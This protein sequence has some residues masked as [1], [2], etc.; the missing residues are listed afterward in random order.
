[1]VFFQLVSA[2][3]IDNE[4]GNGK[5]SPHKADLNW[6]LPSLGTVVTDTTHKITFYWPPEFGTPGAIIV[7]NKHVREFFLKNVS[8]HFPGH[9]DIN[10]LCNSWIYPTWMGKVCS[11]FTAERVFFANNS[12][13][14][15]ETPVGL[16]SWRRRELVRLKGDGTGKRETWD[17]V[18]DYDVYNDLGDPDNDKN[19]QRTVLGGSQEFPY[20]RRCRTGRQ[21]TKTS[22]AYETRK[23]HCILPESFTPGFYVPPD[24]KFP[25]SSLASFRA[26]FF[27]AFSKKFISD[28]ASNLNVL[29]KHFLNLKEIKNLYSKGLSL[30]IDITANLV[31]D[32][33]PFQMIKGIL[34]TEDQA[35]LK[36]PIP[37]I[38]YHDDVAWMKDEEFARQTLS[39]ANPMV[40]QCLQVWPPSSKLNIQIYGPQESSITDQHLLPYLD[41]ISVDEGIES[42]R[43]FVLDYY[44]AYMPYVKRINELATSK[45]YATRTI[46]FLFS[47]GTLKPIAIELCLPPTSVGLGE[48]RVFTPDSS[49]EDKGWLWQLAKAHVKAN[50]SGYHQIVSHWLRT[51]AVVEPFIIATH[52]NMSKLHPIH[53]LLVP[54]FRNTMDIN[55]AA[56]QSLINA[57]GVI[58]KCFSA[59]P[60][61]ME[62]S[63]KAYVEWRFNEQGLPA[64]LLKR[65]MA[66]PDPTNEAIG[67]KL[68]VEDYPY[69]VDG[70]EI[71]GALKSWVCDYT[72]LYY[73]DDQTVESD[74]EVQAWW[75]EII[76]VGHGDK[77]YDQPGWYKMNTLN[78]LN[79]AITTLIWVAS[80]HHAAVNF[81]QYGY[82]GFMPNL[83]STTRRLVPQKGSEEYSKL[84]KEPEAYFLKTLTD[85]ETAT[86]TMAVLEILSKH[87]SD[88]IYLG[89]GSTTEWVEDSRVE[90][91]FQQFR[92]NLFGIEKHIVTRNVN[93]DLKNRCGAV[94]LPYTLLFPNTSDE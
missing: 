87:S 90:N 51:H 73:R 19:L 40:I 6:N 26:H 46:F 45:V 24:E 67:L 23:L 2:D 25:H 82:A 18:Y 92:L 88:E 27:K 22:Q 52:R 58:E 39:G 34:D 63:S 35:I 17:R 3:Q 13:L 94:K 75:K 36:F 72:S 91:L 37:D 74:E 9:E 86:T 93:P 89:Q 79:E 48:R 29:K 16:V 65:G 60:F 66:I 31:K 1:K 44:D 84:L 11:N 70:L 77:K 50:D 20:P 42:K 12:Y 33:M 41:G 68:V 56:R 38:I 64:D 15:E 81:G 55:R 61:G 54:H 59:G 4:T 78:D 28:L 80:A 30:P 83:P 14:P 49:G 47:D 43:L 10:F 21:R 8:I 7:K 62:I 76:E 5:I 85:P 71:W 69:A 57:G 53:K 32:I